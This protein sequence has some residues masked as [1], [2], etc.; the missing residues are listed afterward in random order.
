[1][2]V[3]SWDIALTHIIQAYGVLYAEVDT[4]VAQ[5]ERPARYS[6]VCR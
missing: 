2:V 4:S 1:M 5:D 6:K 3:R